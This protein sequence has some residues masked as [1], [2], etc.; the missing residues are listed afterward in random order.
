MES[1]T[2][3]GQMYRPDGEGR[4]ADA[5][6]AAAGALRWRQVFQGEERQLAVLR[7]WLASM[8]PDCPARDDVISVATELGSNALRH[9]A[10]GR[11]GLFAV[12]VTWHE[13][14]VRVAVADGG[15]PTE[16]HVIEDPAA[17]HGR[18]L[19]VVRGLSAR[20]GVAGDHRGRLVWADVAWDG[21]SAGA[22]AQDPCRAT[23]EDGQGALAR[24]LADV[25]ALFVRSM[26]PRD[27]V[28]RNPGRRRG[29]P[30]WPGPVLAPAV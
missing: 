24:R 17:E 20:T 23:A 28:G 13:S 2:G 19:L 16:P 18:G 7:R 27:R 22:I 30:G 25:P 29:V 9:T 1:D 10:S 14:V 4:G 5:P 21:S 26:A 6:A 8:L 12:E 3:T 15:G 11:S